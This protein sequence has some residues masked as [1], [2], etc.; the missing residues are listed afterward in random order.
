MRAVLQRVS[1]ARVTV[2]GET[3]G[4]CG[5]GLLILLGV[6]RG[7]GEREAEALAAK[8]AGLR[9]F[10]DARGKLNRSVREIG[11]GALVVSNF[12]LYGDC[13]RGR[14]PDFGRAAGFAQAKTLYLAFVRAL[15]LAGVPCETGRFGEEMKVTLTNDGPVTVIVDTDALAIPK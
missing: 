2:A 4:A 3:A 5:A 8:I 15:G 12:T 11:G 9:I 14:R 1:G 6:A 10:E 7:D 13:A